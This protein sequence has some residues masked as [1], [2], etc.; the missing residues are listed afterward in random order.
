MNRRIRVFVINLDTD[1]KRLRWMNDQLSQAGIAFERFSAVTSDS[2]SEE[3]TPYAAELSRRG[4]RA[5]EVGCLLSHL[6]VWRTLAAGDREFGLILEDDVHFAPDFGGFLGKLRPDPEEF[7]I[8][9][10]ETFLP[11]VTLTRRPAFRSGR[12]S[13]FELLSNHGGAAAYVLNRLTARRLAETS[14]RFSFAADIELF[15]PERRSARD[16]KIYQWI[17]APCIQDMHLPEQKRQM[18][19]SANL[20]RQD[21]DIG[22]LRDKKIESLKGFLR[23]IYTF[24]YDLALIP[25]GRA[26]RFIPF[27]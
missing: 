7:C 24:L 11:R 15:D 8:H 2:V 14:P 9:R 18:F 17:P 25:S 6:G 3:Q 1:V 4:L 27:G 16:L 5:S 13:A 21:K 23:P 26:R 19:S 20:D 12:R 10:L 22:V